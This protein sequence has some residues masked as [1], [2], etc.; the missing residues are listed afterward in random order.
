MYSFNTIEEAL[1]DLRAGRLILATDDPDRENE[2]DFICAAQFATTENVNFMATHGKGLICMPMSLEYVQRLRLPQMVAQNTDNHETAFTVSIDHVSTT[3]GISAAER[4]ITAMKCVEEGARPEDFRRP[5]HM[6]PLL[7]RKNGVLERNGHT[8]ATV[9]LLRL[10]GLKECGPTKYGDFRAFGYVN[11]LNGEHHVALVKGEIG[12]GENLLC[13]VHSECLTGD[14]FGSLRCD[15]GEQLASALRQ[16]EAEGRGVLLY[17]RQEGRGIGLINKLRAY[18]LQE[19]GLDTLEANLAL[20]FA[21]DLRE[22]YIGAQ[23]LRDLGVRTMRLLTNNPDKVYQ[24][25]DF[26]LEIVERVPIQMEATQYDRK[27]LRTKREKMGHLLFL[28]EK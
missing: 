15:C 19:Q 28:K 2:G 12:D 21:G 23:I 8:E 25:A 26:G 13:R 20:G 11:R 18:E 16:I 22:Y 1:D 10:A 17:M 14:T 6:F 27:Y 5:G 24:L 4:S 9:D 7:A 3:T